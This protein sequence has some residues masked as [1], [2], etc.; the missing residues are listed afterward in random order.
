[1][2]D[3]VDSRMQGDV[4]GPPQQLPPTGLVPAAELPFPG[5]HFAVFIIFSWNYE[6]FRTSLDTYVAAGWGKRLI[7]IDN[8]LRKSIVNDPGE[9]K[10]GTPCKG[11]W[12]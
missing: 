11:R 3:S 8:T 1:M 7:I 9:A 12:A 5:R 2:Q 10:L 4:P 6:L